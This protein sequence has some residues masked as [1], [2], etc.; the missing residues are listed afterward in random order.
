MGASDSR[1]RAI[2]DAIFGSGTPVTWYVGLTKTTP[3]DDGTNFTEHVGGAYAR[4]AVTNNTTNWPAATTTSGRT[5][6]KNATKV[7]FANPTATWG[8]ILGIGF[9]TALTGGTPEITQ[10]LDDPITVASGNTPV[11]LDINGIEIE[12]D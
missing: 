7:T 6:K 8:T 4:V 12:A 2:L 11:E 10:L 1:E 3:N 9:F 5:V